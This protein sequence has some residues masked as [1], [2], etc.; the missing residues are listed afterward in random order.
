MTLLREDA[1][2]WEFL[3]ATNGTIDP[4]EAERFP[5]ID[6]SEATPA[7]SGTMGARQMTRL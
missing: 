2:Q 1:P 4:N 7:L 3:F 6:L 5:A